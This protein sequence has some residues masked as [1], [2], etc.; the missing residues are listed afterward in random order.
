MAAAAKLLPP[1][2]N[3]ETE[4]INQGRPPARAPS[5]PS[6][7]VSSAVCMASSSSMSSAYRFSRK[8]LALAWE[9]RGAGAAGGEHGR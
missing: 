8:V 9:R 6:L 7:S 5:N 2:F 4:G 1:L 3:R